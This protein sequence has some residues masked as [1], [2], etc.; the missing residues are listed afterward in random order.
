MAYAPETVLSIVKARLNRLATDTSIDEYLLA[1]I[2][3][4]D[5]E[6]ARSGIKLTDETRDTVL[7]ADYV[8]WQYQSRDKQGGMPDWLRL[9]RRERFLQQREDDADAT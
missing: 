4:A 7:L 8:A 2:E 5:C 6:L 3:A 9:A 1:R